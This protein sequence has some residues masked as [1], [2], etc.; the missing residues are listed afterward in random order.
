MTLDRTARHKKDHV[1][2][3]KYEASRCFC[4][5]ICL[6]FYGNAPWAPSH[7]KTTSACSQPFSILFD[8]ESVI[9]T[10]S[11][12]NLYR[13]EDAIEILEYVL[14][15]REEQLGT[16]N[17]DFDDEKKR[18]SELLKEAGKARNRKAKSLQNLIDPNSKRTKK[19]TKRWSG[20]GFRIG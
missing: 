18:L 10:I 3:L 8:V 9:L 17:P 2:N 4:C 6:L 7:A 14:K 5:L 20:L 11:S 19:E 16:A 1:A 13:V 12:W 15:L